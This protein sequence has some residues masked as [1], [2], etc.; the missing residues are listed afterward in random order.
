MDFTNL[1][2]GHVNISG[3][4]NAI[5][6]DAI[7]AN[8]F[9]DAGGN[10]ALP[11]LVVHFTTD[12]APGL[13]LAADEVLTTGLAAVTLSGRDFTTE[14]KALDF[15]T[16]TLRL[17][18][19]GVVMNAPVVGQS[20]SGISLSCTL[21]P[22]PAQAELPPP[23]A[24]SVRGSSKP[25]KPVE[26]EVVGDRLTVKAKLKGGAAALDVAQDLFVRL[27]VGGTDVVVFR[28]PAG[29][30]QAKGK[31]LVASDPDG[32]V[33]HLATGQKQEA[34]AFATVSSSV[35]VVSGKKGVK[36]SFRGTGAD[37]AALSGTA[38]ATIGIGPVSVSKS[39]AVKPRKKKS[40]FK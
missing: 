32:S 30:L 1:P 4:D 33:S 13:D 31:K 27:G 38:I 8:G 6:L 14:G 23:W 24:I 15:S 10:I 29:A 7:Q 3:V 22:I 20:T 16:G 21:D 37:L 12:I 19:Q 17:E 28:A 11:P 39:V 2:V 18:G 36:V 34:G 35:V 25:G 26:G 9:I 40:T 5:I